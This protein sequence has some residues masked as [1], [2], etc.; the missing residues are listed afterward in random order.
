MTGP[1]HRDALNAV[2][3]FTVKKRNS[4]KGGKFLTLGWLRNPSNHHAYIIRA[5]FTDQ[6]LQIIVGNDKAASKK[7][8]TRVNMV[9]TH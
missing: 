7:Y 2:P 8:K 5:I 6:M 1:L 3:I 9:N 4:L